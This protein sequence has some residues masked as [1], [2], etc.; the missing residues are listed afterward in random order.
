[1]VTASWDKTARIWDAASGTLLVQLDH[2]DRVNNATFSHDGRHVV[3]FCG[4]TVRNASKPDGEREVTVSSR[5]TLLWDAVS[6]AE[7]ARFPDGVISVKSSRAGTRV[8]TLSS[9]RKPQ[10]WDFTREAKIVSLDYDGVIRSAAFNADGTRIVTASE[11]KTVRV[12]DTVSGVELACFVQND[13]VNHLAFSVDG[14][15]L[16]TISWRGYARVWDVASGA[17]LA[18]LDH[19]GVTGA[20]FSP[21]GAR[22]LAALGDRTARVWD[23]AS[24]VELARFEHDDE[25]TSAAFSVDGV[26]VVTASSDRTARVWD[27]GN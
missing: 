19:Y 14:A 7:L 6:G 12:W 16:V 22:V 2:D 8:L 13:K 1:V 15:R 9:S 17:E 3:T 27:A 23:V 4:G 5:K 11:D 10:L 25:I 24:R 21:D 18:F 20:S 26:R